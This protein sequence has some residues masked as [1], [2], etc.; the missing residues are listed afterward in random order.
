MHILKLDLAP[1]KVK[2]LCSGKVLYLGECH[3]C[4]LLLF[5]RNKEHHTGPCSLQ[6]PLPSALT[7]VSSF[8][9]SNMFSMS[10][11][12]V[13]IILQEECWLELL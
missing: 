3:Q 2:G 12:L 11:K 8:S 5:S 4:M 9:R 7:S 6:T 13:W 1:L 10:M